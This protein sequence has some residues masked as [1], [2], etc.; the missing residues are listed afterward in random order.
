[1]E[2]NEKTIQELKFQI[3]KLKNQIKEIKSKKKYG[4]VWDEEKEKEIVV[5]ECQHKLPILKELKKINMN[6]NK[7]SP[8]NILI[9]GDNYHALS[10]LSYTHKEKI[11][12]IYIDPPYNTGSGDFIFN[13]K[14]VDKD[15][16][17]KHSKWLLF[18]N[19]RLRLAKNLLKQYG[20][21][22]ISIDDNEVA[23]LRLLCDEIF[24]EDN[25]DVMIWKKTGFGRDGKM[26]N[27]TT[28]RKDHEYIIVCFKSEKLL[29]K[30]R[31]IPNFIGKLSNPDKDPRGNW[32]SGSISRREEA[33]NPS[34]EN[35]YTVT[36][37]T[38][39][40]FT[41]QWDIPQDE[42]TNLNSDNRIY[43]GPEGKNVPRLKIFENEER[44]ITAYSVLEKGTTTEGTAEVE[45]ILGGDFSTLR[46]KPTVLIRT[47]V[48]LASKKD[49]VVLDF[50]AGSGTT[51]QAVLELNQK[52]GYNR[53]FIL[54]TNN[55]NGI[56][57]DVCLPR[58]EKVMGGYKGVNDKLLHKGLGGKLRYFK[59]DFVD[60]DAL[61]HVSDEQRI[62]LTYKAGEM[63]ALKEDTFDEVEKNEW[64]QIFTNGTK[65]TAIYFK[66]DKSK[67]NKLVKQLSNLKSEVALYIFGWGKNE[68]ANEFSEY[69]NI[70]VEDIPE[71][72]IKVYEEIN[73]LA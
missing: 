24:G 6:L 66:E 56:C 19:K 27:T 55:E 20:V 70:R 11:D 31:E 3:E 7:Q 36:S 63:L 69:K 29:N 10:V 37:P 16:S 67:L 46:P 14:I 71:P 1:M 18:M 40:K 28:F 44:Y 49:S 21:M 68:Y 12:V 5:E 72:I 17:F 48:Q 54:C 60:V 62:D 35:Y 39:A 8:T 61:Y 73:K 9:E 64:W 15:D 2:E 41:R 13:D 50:F 30:L 4:L 26:K 52:D 65:Q 51:G 38:R 59:T 32:L 42:F 25:V 58:L 45:N 57:K 23:K 22:F 33:S 53:S 47:L 34:H 43:W